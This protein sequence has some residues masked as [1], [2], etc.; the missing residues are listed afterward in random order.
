MKQSDSKQGPGRGWRKGV[1]KYDAEG[2]E[3]GIRAYLA[4]CD[5]AEPPRKPTWHG[6]AVALKISPDSLS[7][8]L[9]GKNGAT[10]EMG[11][12]LALFAAEL[13]D[14]F[15]QRTDAM[16][17]LS[18][19]QPLFGGFTNR[20]QD[21]GGGKLEINLTVGNASGAEALEYGR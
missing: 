5:A 9:K 2:L 18:M 1:T 15:Q 13:S 20:P 6:A 8:W 21:I 16:A 19:N 17:L 14:R 7:V 11:E 3:R 10:A 4:A 12:T